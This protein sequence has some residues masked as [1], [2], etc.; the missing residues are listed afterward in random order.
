MPLMKYRVAYGK[1]SVPI[2]APTEEDQ[3]NK[4]THVTARQGDVV[5]LDSARAD[6]FTRVRLGVPAKL[7]LIGDENTDTAEVISNPD[8]DPSKGPIIKTAPTVSGAATAKT[9]FD[10]PIT[11]APPA[12]PPTSNPTPPIT[13]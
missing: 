5:I 9:A 12:S 1:H 7:I 10:K 3:A 4:R 6:I 11:P 8:N 2:L 13:K